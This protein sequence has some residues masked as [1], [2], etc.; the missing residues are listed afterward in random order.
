M[1]GGSNGQK[2][3]KTTEFIDQNGSTPGKDLPYSFAFH[4]MSYMNTTHSILIG[5]RVDGSWSGKSVIVQM[6]D[7]KMTDGPVLNSN[8]G[9][10]VACG[11]FQHSNGTKYVILAGGGSVQTTQLLNVDSVNEGWHSGT[12][13][14]Q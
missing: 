9:D 7:F 8:V 11:N 3:Q 2:L 13:F 14:M 6:S 1:T 4:C 10:V 12:K 5:G